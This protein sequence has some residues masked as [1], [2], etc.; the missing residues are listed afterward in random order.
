MDENERYEV[1]FS[2]VD[3]PRYADAAIHTWASGRDLEGLMLVMTNE[4][5]ALPMAM[6]E[7]EVMQALWLQ[8]ER[9]VARDSQGRPVIR[10][11]HLQA[12][13]ATIAPQEGTS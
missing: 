12:V 10:A 6:T 9:F 5:G 11:V 3:D 1:E 4:E 8:D 7:R 2:P 13:L